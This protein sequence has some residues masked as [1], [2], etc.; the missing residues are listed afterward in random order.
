M[1]SVGWHGLPDMN[2]STDKLCNKSSLPTL[3]LKIIPSA[4]AEDKQCSAQ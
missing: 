4:K 1:T 3:F 2:D